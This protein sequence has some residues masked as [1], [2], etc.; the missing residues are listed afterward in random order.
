MVKRTH[1][2]IC[3]HTSHTHTHTHSLSLFSNYRACEGS[4]LPN[5]FH[6]HRFKNLRARY[7]KFEEEKKEKNIILTTDHSDTVI[8]VL[9]TRP[10]IKIGGG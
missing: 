7:L 5:T 2:L 10:I 9:N 6:F 3:V 8:A 4:T 1:T